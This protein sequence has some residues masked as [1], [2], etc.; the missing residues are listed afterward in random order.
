MR[1]LGLVGGTGPE[2]TI[3]YYHEIV[4][5]VQKKLGHEVLPPLT[6]ESISCFD[7][8]RFSAAE[9]YAGMAEYLLKALRSLA[10]A[11]AE[12][13]AFTGNTPHVVFDEVEQA[14]PIPLV[15]LITPARDAVCARGLK[16][17]GL[18][19]TMTTMN[20]TF[21]PKAFKGTGVRLVL[22][23]QAEKHLI[24]ERIANEIE[25]G[26]MKDSTRK[27]FTDIML[28]MIRDDGIE[29]VILGCTE[30]PLLFLNSQLPLERFDPMSLHIER[31]INMI[32]E[33]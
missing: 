11:G 19:G 20:G 25:V 6:I 5:G 24:Q 14:S 1:K 7:L 27:E 32:T 9:D 28:R 26:I 12:F 10:A 17:V 3:H 21:I 29:A 30:L 13:A 31:L 8:F 2:S 15:S 33:R 18:L 22:P 16:N 4:Y 23:G